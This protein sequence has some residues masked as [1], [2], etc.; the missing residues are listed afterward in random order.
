MRIGKVVPQNVRAQIIARDGKCRHCGRYDHPE[1]HHIRPRHMGGELQA[2][3]LITLCC[4]CHRE[5]EIYEMSTNLTFREWLYTPPIEA[6]RVFWMAMRRGEPPWILGHPEDWLKFPM[7][8][9]ERFHA[10]DIDYED[11]SESDAMTINSQRKNAQHVA[12]A[13]RPTWLYHHRKTIANACRRYAE[14][15]GISWGEA[16]G[17][18][19]TWT[20]HH[21]NGRNYAAITERG[22]V[23]YYQGGR[24]MHRAPRGY[25]TI[26]LASHNSD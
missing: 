14:R 7:R 21:P 3:N 19:S 26:T 13:L 24:I 16:E 25:K 6:L 8:S 5:W 22:V 20:W 9:A 17:T 4:V 11:Q 2:H 23:W 10:R 1:V 18:D 12:A 15:A